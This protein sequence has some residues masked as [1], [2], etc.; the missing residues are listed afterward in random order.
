MSYKKFRNWTFT[1]FSLSTDYVECL[2]PN[3]TYLIYGK[4]TCPTTGR[5]HHQGYFELKTQM[6]LNAIKK[7]LKNDTIHL[8]V[9]RGTAEQNIKYCE[10]DRDVFVW[11]TPKQQGKRTDLQIMR[12]LINEGKTDEEILEEVSSVQSAKAIQTIRYMS[13]PRRTEKPYVKWFW[14]DTGTGKTET[15]VK[16]FNDD[17]DL[18]SYRNG[19]VIGYTGNK[20]VLWDEFR[21]QIP[22]HELLIMLDRYKC[23]INVKGGH[24]NFSPKNIIITSCFHPRKCYKNCDENINQLLRRIDEIREFKNCSDVNCSEVDGNSTRPLLSEVLKPFITKKN[25][26]SVQ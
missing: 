19:F 10:K 5:K 20:N 24:C 11:G 2:S 12:E 6:S 14:G 8:E 4:E 16:E 25:N 9:A 7:K 18:I 26:N 21:S 23:I 3:I 1:D 15:A 17:Y 13:I 22:L